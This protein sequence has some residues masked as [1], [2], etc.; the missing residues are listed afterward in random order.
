[1]DRTEAKHGDVLFVG[2]KGSKRIISHVALIHNVDHIFHC[3]LKAGTAVIQ[4]DSDFF[5]Q[6]EQGFNCRQ[7]LSYIDH[8]NK[9]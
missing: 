7:M 9:A 1:M 8:R 6:Y 5:S 4:K 3:S 2:K